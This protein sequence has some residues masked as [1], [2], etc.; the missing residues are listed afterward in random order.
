MVVAAW[1][2]SANLGD[3]LVHAA[4]REKLRSRGVRTTAVSSAPRQGEKEDDGECHYYER[5]DPDPV[6]IG[7][8]GRR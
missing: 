4:L 8:F 2:G 7:S 6:F 1:V 3:E 5:R